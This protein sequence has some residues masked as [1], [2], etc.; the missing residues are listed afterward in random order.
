MLLLLR[1][2]VASISPKC[3]A[4]FARKMWIKKSF[5]VHD[6]W[7]RYGAHIME[8]G[9]RTCLERGTHILILHTHTR[10]VSIIRKISYS[11]IPQ[12]TL[13]DVR[14]DTHSTCMVAVNKQWIRFFPF[15]DAT[16]CVQRTRV[17]SAKF[18]LTT[19]HPNLLLEL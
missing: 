13:P 2:T 5:T 19:V 16:F 8:N 14:R 6:K 9:T 1:T 10:F 18:L 12:D 3:G 4:S 17:A 15:H 11:L 7:L